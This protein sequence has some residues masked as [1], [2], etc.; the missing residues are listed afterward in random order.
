MPFTLDEVVPWGRS[1]DEY[2]EMFV[3]SSDDLAKTILGCGDGPASFNAVLSSRGG[4]V[5]SIDPLYAHAPDAIRTRI[6]QITPIVLEQTRAAANQF[7]WD[8]IRSVEH[9]REVRL[10]AMDTFLADFADESATRRYQQGG[11]P[12]LPFAD[13]AFDLALCSHFLFL[14]AEHHSLQFHVDSLVELCR[15]APEARIFPVLE[16]SGSESRHLRPAIAAVESAGFI[17]EIVAVPYE[18]QRGGN[19]MLVVRRS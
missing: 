10:A 18:F 19:R 11:L 8:R 14:Y 13:D 2:V 6:Q 15:V 1:F 9:L 5:Q 7:N 4:M 17:A 16:L 3:L 12:A